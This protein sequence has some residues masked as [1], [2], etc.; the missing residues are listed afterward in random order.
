MKKTAVFFA[1][2]FEEIEALTPVDILR[3]GGVDV[4][5]VSVMGDRLIHGSHDI[6][7]YADICIEE[8][9]FDT[10][11]MIVLPGGKLG[12]QNL[13]KCELLMD[14]VKEFDKAGKFVAAICAAPTILGRLGILKGRL[15]TCYGGMEDALEGADLTKEPVAVSDH[16][17][18]S[19]GMGTSV[20]FGL[21]LLEVLTDKT[22]A[23]KI[24]ASV[25]VPGMG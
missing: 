15:A 23:D 24:G 5:T 4:V 11:D 18:T 19:R 10:V 22:N 1:D 7:I 8:L 2:G 16:I 21:K 3:R 9:D 12:H 14:K 13:E 25:M 20:D 6:D 17:I